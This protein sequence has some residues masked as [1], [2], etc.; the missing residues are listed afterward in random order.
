MVVNTVV[1]AAKTARGALRKGVAIAA[2]RGTLNGTQTQ[3]TLDYAGPG[4]L[5]REVE[6][7]FDS[8]PRK[9]GLRAT[10]D[11][12]FIAAPIPV[13]GE[14][15]DLFYPYL[16]AVLPVAATIEAQIAR[17]RSKPHRRRLRSVQRSPNWEYQVVRTEEA[18]DHFLDSLH[19]P[20]V[21]ERFVE[22]ARLPHRSLL[23][24]RFKKSG[25]VVQVLCDGAI[26]SGALL[27]HEG[28][29]LDYDRNGFGAGLSKRPTELAERTA[30]VELAIFHVAQELGVSDIAMGFCR[31]FLRC[32]LY[33]H[34]RRLGCEFRPATGLPAF[35][36]KLPRALRPAFLSAVPMLVG[37]K[38]ASVARLGLVEHS[39]RRER[40]DWKSLVRNLNVPSVRHIEVW[41]NASAARV[42]LFVGYL[43][44]FAP[45]RTVSVYSV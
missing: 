3:V 22:R 20:F 33:T 7:F 30:A 27:F 6:W 21:N 34:K 36:L 29:T 11:V 15:V 24:R 40:P 16:D 41:T 35:R 28:S 18:F 19:L 42:E 25:L 44:T 1:K 39:P 5:S 13:P 4:D 14:D 37:K 45:G 17:V 10:P 32:G 31:A 38:A 26:V 2:F 23:R 43:D 9:V 8:P 12:A